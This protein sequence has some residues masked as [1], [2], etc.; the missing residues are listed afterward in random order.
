MRPGAL[1]VGYSGSLYDGRGVGVM[2]DLARRLPDIDVH[3]LG[4]PAADA[5]ALRTRRDRPMNLHVHGLRP[6]ADA[7]RLQ[8]AMDVLLAP[9]ARTVATPGGV[10][11][12]RWMS[13]MKVFEY[14]AAGRAIVCSDLP[15]LREVLEH[16]TT[17][18]L[19]DPDDADAWVSAVVRLR[20]DVPLREQLGT[21]GRTMH[22]ERFTWGARTSELL[23]IW[24][25]AR[26]DQ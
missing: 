1:Q 23:N 17:A 11:T 6:V 4:G 24:S 9:Y 2:L 14:L 20:D 15:V 10:D 16:S 25:S 5:D 26:G 3:V 13:P 18:L 21:R 19:A 22:A 7:E 12:S 8:A